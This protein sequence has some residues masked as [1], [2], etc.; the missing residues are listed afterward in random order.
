MANRALK[1]LDHEKN[2][3]EPSMVVTI[4][5]SNV[6]IFQNTYIAQQNF[7]HCETMPNT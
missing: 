5:S 3:I 6:T 1:F 7:S 2:E 4:N